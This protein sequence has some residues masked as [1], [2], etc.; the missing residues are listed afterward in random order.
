MSENTPNSVLEVALLAEAPEQWERF[1]DREAKMERGKAKWQRDIEKI[2]N[3]ALTQVIGIPDRIREAKTHLQGKDII[4]PVCG[5]GDR[6]NTMNRKPWC[7]KCNRQLLPYE[8]VE[9]LNHF[10]IKAL[11]KTKRLDVTFQ[12]DGTV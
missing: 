4:C 8:K 12:G 9:R 6:G 7:P 1:Q 11:P 5:D 10:S 3:D 2:R